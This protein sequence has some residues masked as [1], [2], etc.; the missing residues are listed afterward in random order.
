MK[1][2]EYPRPPE[3]T[4]IGIHWAPGPAASV[5]LGEVKDFWIPELKAMGVKSV[6]LL[7][8]GGL[9]VAEAFLENGIM[10]IVRIYRYQP[11]SEDPEEGTLSERELAIV[12]EFVDAGV[13]YIE[14]NNEPNLSTEWKDKKKPPN[15]EEI[16]ARNAIK[17][18]EAIIKLGGYP[19]IPALSVGCNWDLIGSI[20]EQGGKDLLDGPVWIAIHNYDLNHPLDY[21]YDEVNQT[22]KE[23][24]PEEYVA[25]GR[26]AW[27]GPTWGKRSL[28]F[29]N[30]Q[31]KEG[32][33][34]GFTIMDDHSCWLAYERFAELSRKHLG[35]V[36]PILSTENGP[37]VGEDSDPRYPTT[38]KELHKEK[39][40]QMARAMMGTS[41]EHDAAPPY[42]FNTSFWLLA[43]SQLRTVGW[44]THSW[45]SV[46]WP[47]GRLPVV[48]ALKEEPKQPRK[49]AGEEK[50]EGGETHLMLRSGK[51]GSIKGHVENG[52]G[53]RVILRNSTTTETTCD[54]EGNFGFANLHQGEY[55][56][57]IPEKGLSQKVEVQGGV[58]ISVEFEISAPVSP[59]EEQ[60]EQ[61]EKPEEGPK[62]PEPQ[63]PVHEPEGPQEPT[64]GPEEPQEEHNAEEEEHPSEKWTFN[65]EQGGVGPGF[66][67]IRCSVEGRKGVKIRVWTDGWDGM[68]QE[69]GSKPEYGPYACELSPL[70]SGKYYLSADELGVEKIPINLDGVHVVWVTFRPETEKPREQPEEPRERGKGTPHATVVHEERKGKLYLFLAEVP[71][72]KSDLL[73][74]MNYISRFSPEVGDNLEEA[75]KAEN[76]LVISS[77]PDEPLRQILESEGAKVCFA[78]P[79]FSETLEKAIS[80]GE[81]LVFCG[82]GQDT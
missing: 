22:G 8:D 56:V 64:H 59:A 19:A 38:T 25:Y 45:Y 47:G 13:K 10:P 78:S 68:V 73:S 43:S 40:L 31:R 76:V 18:M 41:T 7:H 81:A 34:P 72:Q 69:S 54:E 33:N 61:P 28:E 57:E 21:P 12:K 48:E 39:V 52:A 16:V 80:L 60:P 79:P 66:G 26:S 51:L 62:P 50:T 29:V 32:K 82:G 30:E 35:R 58:T 74:M 11:N 67:V 1:L 46:I 71:L 5:G 75:G 55:V 37:I 2:S 65:V 42:Y 70:G 63:E 14:F 44:E 15:A 9:N 17:D 24:T 53:L 77:A 6:K 36:L 3:D 20:I 23:I 49:L 4:G 27:T